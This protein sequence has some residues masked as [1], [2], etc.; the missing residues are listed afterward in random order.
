MATMTAFDVAFRNTVEN[1]QIEGGY[2]LTNLKTD[3]GRR[4]YAGISE[5][6]HPQ[7]LG[8][9]LI[10]SGVPLTDPSLKQ[11]VRTFYYQT[12]WTPISGDQLPQ[13]LAVQVFDMAVNSG[14]DD[15]V[16]T[17]QIALGTVRADGTLGPKTL[18]AV[19]SAARPQLAERFFAHRIYFYTQKTPQ[20]A[21]KDNG[22]GWMNRLAHLLLTEAGSL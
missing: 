4:T 16:R 11:L 9:K 1:P 14:P 3:P 20:Q 17:L 5:R 13:W 6:Y 10:D 2:V 8:W 21:W 7:W 12:F 22:R 18:G 19:R 15:A